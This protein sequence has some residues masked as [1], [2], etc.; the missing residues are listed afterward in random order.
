MHGL[1]PQPYYFFKKIYDFIISRNFGIVVLASHEKRTIA[2]AMFFHF[3]EKATFKYAASNR[4]YQNLRPSNLVMWEGIKRYCENG[5]K[6]LCFGRTEIENKGLRQYKAGWGTKESI[7]K[8]YRFNVK[9][10]DVIKGNPGA[11]RIQNRVFN[12]MPT[13]LL[14]FIGL[15]SY[16]HMR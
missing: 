16:K 12:K 7:I 14:K 2:G 9:K 10:G 15:I 4:A 3:G 6:T 8:Y 11:S 1:P 13:A 5:Y